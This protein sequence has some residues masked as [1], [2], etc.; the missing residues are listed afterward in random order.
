MNATPSTGSHRTW[1]H[2]LTVED[3]HRLGE[4][5]VLYEDDRVE[6]IEGDL[7]AMAP[8]GSRHAACVRRLTDIFYAQAQNK[9][10]VSVQSPI[11]LGLHS[12]P[13][14]DL[15]L[16]E[17]RADHYARAHPA[18][19]EVLL[20]VEVADTSAPCDRELKLPLY[21][22]HGIAEV[23]LVDIANEHIEVYRGPTPEGYT[24]ARTAARR[25]VLSPA[26]LPQHPSAGGRALVR[27]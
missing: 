11:R 19:G 26:A 24:E 21:A 13:Q 16:V 6:L 20:V 15:A 3:F 23:W 12:E 27:P 17:P 18:A 8:I 22:V 5:G 14:P 25:E 4:A 2:R 1:H 9:V 7:I 10:Q